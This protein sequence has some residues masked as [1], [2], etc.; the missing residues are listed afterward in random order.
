MVIQC[1]YLPFEFE[2]INDRGIEKINYDNI[3]FCNNIDDI[4]N[5]LLKNT[6]VITENSTVL[7]KFNSSKN[8]RL[9]MDGFDG[10]T[11]ESLRHDDGIYLTP[12]K[13]VVSVIQYDNFPLPPGMY[14][15]KIYF[16]DN[17]YYCSYEIKSVRLDDLTW[18]LM[19]KDV[20][21]SIK[22]L[23]FQMAVQKN[24]PSNNRYI[25][26]TLGSLL[27][28]MNI[29]E[30][31]FNKVIAAL[32]DISI[33]PHSKISK[34]YILTNKTKILQTDF[35][36]DKLDAKKISLSFAYAPVKYTDYQLTENAY[37]KRIIINLDSIIRQFINEIR[38]KRDYLRVKILNDKHGREKNTAEYNRDLNN[39]NYIHRYH[40]KARK[41][42]NIINKVKNT[43]WFNV[44]NEN[45][46]QKVAS[47]SMLDPRYAIL[48]KLS[49]DLNSQNI[50]YNV[51][52]KLSFIWHNSYKLYELWGIIK[53]VE[54]FQKMGFELQKGFN[55]EKVD[56]ELR[57]VGL[58]SGDYFLFTKGALDVKI[59]YDTMIPKEKG[60]ASLDA[61]PV[62]T[63]GQHNNPDCKID[64]YYKIN[65][66]RHYI[67][68][69]IIDFKYRTKNSLWKNTYTNSKHQLIS[70]A[71]ETRSLCIYGFDNKSSLSQRPV[72]SV[73]ALYP[74][75]Y[76]VSEETVEEDLFIKLI[77]FVPGYQDV[78]EHHID[79][80]LSTHVYRGI[81]LGEAMIYINKLS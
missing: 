5:N 67:S 12:S 9:E 29:I 48:S 30:Q 1:N 17:C 25:E 4:N 23:A 37:M 76:N 57:I 71:N 49:K 22:L 14:I 33:N 81:K 50:R 74:D 6:I 26:G 11:L 75:R 51:D 34:K 43:N 19:A 20:L 42:K 24:L 60:D 3:P 65:N 70:Y 68:S 2:L 27:L 32:D 80:F 58:S 18:E 8:F 54:T 63:V 10:S 59:S 31:Q 79:E 53:I 36:C 46:L 35:K 13:E 77:S 45:I 40:L 28:K 64:F 69:L 66:E 56:E 41:I 38:E 62:Y 47:Q 78:I 61:D 39:L 52:D 55:V 44:V 73:W 7:I 15:I 16:E 72:K 21:E